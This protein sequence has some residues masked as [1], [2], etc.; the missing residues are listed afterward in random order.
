MAA[1]KNPKGKKSEK[2]LVDALRIVLNEPADKDNPKGARKVR[3]VAEQLV[4]Q[5]M[6]GDV[7]AIREVWDRMEGK[8]VQ[9]VNLGGQDGNPVGTDNKWTVEFINATPESKPKT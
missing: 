6:K 2:P 7:K 1:P 3:R 5:A 4:D 9:A 8:A